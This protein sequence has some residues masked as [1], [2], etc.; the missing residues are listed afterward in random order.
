MI[1]K[2]LFVF[3]AFMLL[4]LLYT[5]AQVTIGS[6]IDPAQGA[7]LQL[8]ENGNAGA[9]SS[10]GLAM[11]RVLLNTDN[12]FDPIL[13]EAT[14]DDKERHEGLTVYHL[15]NANLC[16]GIYVWNSSIWNR[17]PKPCEISINCALTQINGIYSVGTMLTAAN[18]ITLQLNVPAASDGGTYHI[19]TDTRNGITFS[20]TGI[21][22]KGIQTVMLAGTG[23]PKSGG[24]RT[25]FTIYADFSNSILAHSPCTAVMTPQI[26]PIGNA[27]ILGFGYDTNVYGFFLNTS[28][29]R[30]MATSSNN[31]GRTANSI[32]QSDGFAINTLGGIDML[33][34][35]NFLNPANGLKSNP[36]IIINGY[37][38]HIEEAYPTSKAVTDALVNYLK[39]GGVVIL[40]DEYKG[41][42][43]I[44]LRICKQLFPQSTLNAIPVSGSTAFCFPIESSVPEGDDILDGPFSVNNWTDKAKIDLRGKLWGND[45]SDAMAITGLPADKIIV[46]SYAKPVQGGGTQGVTMFRLKDYNLFFVGDGGFVSNNKTYNISNPGYPDFYAGGS[47]YDGC[48]C[49]LAMDT[50]CRPI[51]RINF[52][53]GFSWG[54]RVVYNS[55]LF[56]NIMY[57]AAKNAR[58]NNK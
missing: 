42:Y 16:A 24:S 31:F 48:C 28:G 50:S 58:S 38:S 30:V 52:A 8:K 20:A 23:T 5:Q 46:Y 49:P 41:D 32:V 57:W 19:Y 7:I 22:T 53:N 26:L 45:A 10:K 9:N 4:S 33:T 1:T 12:D 34:E 36:D 56:A 15:G 21:L 55:Q 39:T 17:L 47:Y 14:S 35:A 3:G 27:N 2:K 13:A 11:P 25:A 44:A 51:P 37:Y 43:S 6:G 18:T 29:S 40:F 54:S